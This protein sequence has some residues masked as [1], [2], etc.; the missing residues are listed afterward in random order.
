[1]KFGI[2]AILMLSISDFAILNNCFSQD[3]KYISA[4]GLL[5]QYP[6][7]GYNCFY[8]IKCK[9]IIDTIDIINNILVRE[10]IDTSLNL[11]HDYN[12]L[13]FF[14]NNLKKHEYKFDNEK[15]ETILVSI[16]YESDGFLKDLIK[17][18]TYS[19]E[20]NTEKKIRVLFYNEIYF[21]EKISNFATSRSVQ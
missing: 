12:T 3:K 1:M 19:M 8:F 10:N 20:F 9:K 13:N 21:V 18:S 6:K 11:S 4:N 14:Y 17:E 15:S 16:K 7:F 5:V 2:L